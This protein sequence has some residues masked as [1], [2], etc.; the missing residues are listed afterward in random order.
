MLQVLNYTS[1]SSTTTDNDSNAT[2][3]FRYSEEFH[4]HTDMK[5]IGINPGEV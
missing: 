3:V 1:V 5:S 4:S 2:K